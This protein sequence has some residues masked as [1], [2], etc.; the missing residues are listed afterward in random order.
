MRATKP[1]THHDLKTKEKG[2]EL[3]RE[4]KKEEKKKEEKKKKE[5]RS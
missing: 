1:R 2:G 3:G 4:E 5:K